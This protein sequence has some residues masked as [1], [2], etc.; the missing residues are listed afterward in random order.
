MYPQMSW[1]NAFIF[2]SS[3]RNVLAKTEP[4]LITLHQTRQRITL[5]LPRMLS[6]DTYVAK[7]YIVWGGQLWKFFGISVWVR[8]NKAFRGVSVYLHVY[9]VREHQ[10]HPSEKSIFGWIGGQ[11][12][13]FADERIW[14][15]TQKQ[16]LFSWSPILIWSTLTRVRDISQRE[17][18]K[19]FENEGSMQVSKRLLLPLHILENS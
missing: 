5:N 2:S 11:F 3:F 6:E 8:A 12:S 1:N 9:L 19:G 18:N 4:E 13:N 16:I 7:S 15:Q 14:T 10:T 17:V